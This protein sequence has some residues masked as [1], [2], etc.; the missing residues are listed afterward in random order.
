MRFIEGISYKIFRYRQSTAFFKIVKEYWEEVL[1][2]NLTF[3]EHEKYNN[4]DEIT[5]IESI[6]EVL[7]Y[8]KIFT[9]KEEIESCFVDN[10]LILSAIKKLGKRENFKVKKLVMFNFR[11]I[12][13]YSLPLI[14]IL[15]DKRYVIITNIQEEHLI[16]YDTQKQTYNEIL[17]EDIYEIWYGDILIIKPL[18]RIREENF[19]VKWFIKPL[20][21]YKKSLIEVLTS[22]FFLQLLALLSPLIMQVIIDKVLTHNSYNTLKVLSLTMLLIIFFE[23]LLGLAKN[24]I[25]TNIT[26][27]VD[28]LLGMKVFR[29]LVYLPLPFF[30]ERRTG[31]V[32][33]K[34]REV[35]NVRNF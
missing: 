20:L 22:T 23:F 8:F 2:S 21:I 35:E 26:S 31:D 30:E 10:Q 7:K 24:Y 28:V 4:L 33:T 1:M 9:D 12:K 34:V 18:K 27:K 25:F 29:H 13:K 32:L 6:Y 11:K 5:G 16:F 17:I 19:S 3:N 15:N 14:F